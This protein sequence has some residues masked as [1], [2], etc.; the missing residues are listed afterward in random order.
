M[1]RSVR[2]SSLVGAYYW[3]PRPGPEGVT[4]EL[5]TCHDLG[6]WDGVSHREFWPHVL[7]RLAVAWGLDAGALKRRLRD[8]HTG[9][10]RG[11]IVPPDPGY[12]VIHGDDAPSFKWLELVKA[13]FQL[14]GVEVT[15]EFTEHEKMLADDPRAVQAALGVSLYGN[16]RRDLE[17]GSSGCQERNIPRDV[18][19][20]GD[21]GRRPAS[22]ASCA[23]WS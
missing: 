13:R 19:P 10:P 9:V 22:P 5:V 20:I 4:W 15:P 8:H 16:H 6:V 17:G 11:R 1:S 18:I 23:S 7:E 21:S 12:I 3:F 2:L 14:I